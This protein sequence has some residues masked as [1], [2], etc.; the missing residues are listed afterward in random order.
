M[1]NDE[2]GVD[3]G[4]DRLG[5]CQFDRRTVLVFDCTR[6]DAQ[7]SSGGMHPAH[8]TPTPSHVKKR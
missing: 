5:A 2:R 6:H 8:K 7:R 3:E 4:M 1:S